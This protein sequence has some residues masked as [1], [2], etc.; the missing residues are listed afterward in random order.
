MRPN[1]LQGETLVH[2]A[3]TLRPEWATPSIRTILQTAGTLPAENYLHAVQAVIAYATATKPDGSWAKLTPAFLAQSGPHWESS[4]PRR[5]PG[6]VVVGPACEEHPE[7]EAV[8]CRCC[9]ADV[10]TGMRRR[11]QVGRRLLSVAVDGP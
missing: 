9:W 3:H 1:H 2:L 10:K 8:S 6:S 5:L 7:Q 4:R 11:D